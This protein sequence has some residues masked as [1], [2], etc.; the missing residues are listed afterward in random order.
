MDISHRFHI[1]FATKYRYKVLRGEMWEHIREIIRQICK[2]MGVDIVKDVLA[3][4][5]PIC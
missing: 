3:H 4:D 1:V 2:L 5:H